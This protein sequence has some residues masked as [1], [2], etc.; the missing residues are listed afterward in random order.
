MADVRRMTD[1]AGRKPAR[2]FVNIPILNEIDLIDR[3]LN[4]VTNALEAYDCIVL[5]VDDGSTDGTLER[6]RAVVAG[7]H[8]R[9]ALL[10]RKK[11]RA[12][13]QRGA[14]LLAGLKWGLGA[15]EFD[16]FV[17]MDGDL[18]HIPEDLPLGIETILSGRCDIAIAS[19]YVDGSITTGRSFGRR[20]VSV[21]CNVAVRAMIDRRVHDYSNGYRFYNRRAA[22]LIP[23]YEIRYGSPVY[24][25]EAMAIWLRNGMRVVEIPGHYVGRNEGFS[26]LRLSDYMKAAVGV[27]EIGARYRVTG[28]TRATQTVAAETPDDAPAAAAIGPGTHRDR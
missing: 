17:E 23:Q 28:F 4:R 19:K 7:S 3:L 26:K 24:L 9:V 22:A 12:D 5:I 8:G 20:A 25:T 11:G 21:I 27:V 14:A 16:V 2:V 18:S 10:S 6:V 1:T 13:C 15:G